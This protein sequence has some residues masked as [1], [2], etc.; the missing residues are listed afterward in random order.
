MKEEKEIGYIA[1]PKKKVS[2]LNLEVNK[3]Y[4]SSDIGLYR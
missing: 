1:L 2:E 3:E 4:D